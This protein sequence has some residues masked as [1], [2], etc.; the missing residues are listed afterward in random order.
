MDSDEIKKRV[1]DSFS[2][3]RQLIATD[4]GQDSTG[5]II[6][7]LSKLATM[8]CSGEF[9]DCEEVDFDRELHQRT[10]EAL[11]INC[12]PAPEHGRLIQCEACFDTDPDSYTITFWLSPDTK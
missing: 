8:I 5:P 11:I 4:S 7:S 12:S 10:C 6:L 2:Y 9:D 3:G 1:V